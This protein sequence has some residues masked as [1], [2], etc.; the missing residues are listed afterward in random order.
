MGDVISL[1]EQFAIVSESE[2]ASAPHRTL[3][4]GDTF[5]VFDLHGD[6]AA[7]GMGEQGL[8]HAGT[9]FLSRFE[10]LLGMRRPLLL[11][12][13]ISDDN[14]TLAVD[15]TNPDIVRD[16][17]VALARGALHMFRSR[18]LWNG[19]LVERVRLANHA[20][21]PISVP[22]VLRFDADFVDLFEVRGMHRDR[23][24]TRS[25][26][27]VSDHRVVLTY[28]GLDNVERRTTVG[29]DLRPE[30]VDAGAA[31]FAIS[32]APQQTADLEVAVSCEMAGSGHHSRYSDLLARSKASASE[33]SAFECVVR[34]SSDSF[35]RWFMRS[36]SD[37]RMM[38]TA[39]PAGIYPYAGIPWFSTPFGRDGL[40]TALQTLWAAPDIAR[41]VLAFLAETQATRVVEAQDAEPGKILHEMRDG[42]MAALGEIPFGRYY[43]SADATPLFVMLADAYF[44]RTA[45]AAF[46]DRL[47]PHIT[48]A[49]DWIDHF[50]DRDG[51]GFVEYARHSSTGLVQQGWKDSYDSIFHADG[52]LAEPPIA[53]CEIQAYVY[54][55][56]SGAARLAAT[57]G[58][59]RLAAD[60]RQRA[61]R[62]R[63]RFDEQFWS[64][65]LGT[66]A[67]ALDGGKRPCLVRSSNAGHCLFAGIAAPERARG[68]ADTLMGDAM[69]AGWGVRTIAAGESRYNPMSYHNG[70]V[71][72][73]DNALIAAGLAHYGLTAHASRLMRASLDLS[74]EVDVHRLPEL[75][76]GFHRRHGEGPTL[77]PVACAPQAWAAGAVYMLLGACLGLHIDAT[78]RQVSFRHPTLPE[79]IDWVRL[80]DLKVGAGT[81]DL[82]LTRHQHGVGI[83]MLHR[84]GE[85]EIATIK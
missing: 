74:L 37:L 10:L 83:E 72:P 46:I 31:R 48:A 24:G 52:T 70:S 6:I 34:S 25:P 56:W 53:T 41:G 50:G 77:Y 71:W 81:V 62:V 17:R 2:R 78:A 19:Q 51:D 73:H 4:H 18:L 14:T 33:R 60:C 49:L 39:T 13:N 58:D 15:L 57:R 84:D 54:G 66:F 61:A 63:A 9:R 79:G 22:L 85:I 40:I 5:G 23:R 69:F 30:R 11:G 43:G 16:E 65:E 12:S 68:A 32:L 67:L 64:D 8:Y 75:I 28:R 38:L 59:E 21:D 20:R 47:W 80:T 29:W 82:L 3:K 26:A 36:A 42:E 1:E 55:A 35:N 27:E 76:C 44:E 45:D 7:A